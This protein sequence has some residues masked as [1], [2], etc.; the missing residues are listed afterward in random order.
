MYQPTSSI[1]P[2]TKGKSR[3]RIKCTRK[4]VSGYDKTFRISTNTVEIVM[5]MVVGTLLLNGGANVSAVCQSDTVGDGSRSLVL[6]L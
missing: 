5:R 6:T 4:C 2:L 3:S 1:L